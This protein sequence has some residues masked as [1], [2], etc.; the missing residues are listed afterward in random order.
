M[1]GQEVR[2]WNLSRYGAKRAEIRRRKS[3]FLVWVG[4]TEVQWDYGRGSL[5]SPIQPPCILWYFSLFSRVFST[6][7]LRPRCVSPRLEFT[8]SLI[9]PETVA[10]TL[11]AV[12]HWRRWLDVLQEGFN[13]EN[14]PPS[15][16]NKSQQTFLASL[17]CSLC[18]WI[19]LLTRFSPLWFIHSG[20]L[21]S[22]LVSISPPT[23]S[24]C[25]PSTQEV[26]KWKMGGVKTMALTCC[27]EKEMKY[28]LK[29]SSLVGKNSA[30]NEFFCFPHYLSCFLFSVALWD[31]LP[32]G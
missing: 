29:L 23:V 4:S 20:M 25:S 5:G 27:L 18:K 11:P 30:L 1:E 2:D 31:L 8:L 26:C 10:V 14:W 7:C 28:L 22:K 3:L 24:H 17:L 9:T 12:S 21:L 19:A 32:L 16:G 15:V 6:L 13:R